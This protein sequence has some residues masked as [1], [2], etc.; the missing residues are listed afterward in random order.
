MSAVAATRTRGP[1]TI[2]EVDVVNVRITL[3]REL[4]NDL[5]LG[6][7]WMVLRHGYACT[8]QRERDGH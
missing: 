1:H 6:Q 8:P 5:L 2:P 3:L 7:R 4:R